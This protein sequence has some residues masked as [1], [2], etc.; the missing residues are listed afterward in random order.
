MREFRFPAIGERYFAETL[1]C[2]LQVRV[3]PKPEF[4]KTYAFF[5]S[6][7][8]SIDTDFT[9]DGKEMT[10]PDGVA[11]YLE[12]KMFDMPD[13][14]AMQMFSRVGGSPNAFTGYT[15]TAYYVECTENPYENLDIL[16]RFVSTPHF[17]EENVEK[18]RGII[19]QEI[20]MYEDS[21]DSRLYENL[22]AALYDHHPVRVP[23]AGSVESIGKITAQTLR[24]CHRAFYDP[25]N[26]MLCVAGPVEPEQVLET[27][28]RVLP[29]KR[30]GVSARDYGAPES[31]TGHRS[32]IETQMEVSMPGF[33][34]GF[35]CEPPERGERTLRQELLGDI[36]SELLA[37]ESSALYTRLYE[38]GL[39]DC[40]FS[41][42]YEGLKGAAMLSVSGDSRD[43]DAVMDAILR[44]AE[45]I[46]REG[47]DRALFGRLCKSAFGRRVRELDSFENICYR[48]CQSCFEGAEYYDFPTLYRGITAEEAAEF[49]KNTVR[50]ERA[51][52]SIVRPKNKEG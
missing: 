27:A 35:K 16:L 15:M 48:M 21:A 43:P 23:I 31:M 45:R 30:G 51:A 41:V 13:G 19:A 39:I 11:H 26:M 29:G 52:I 24:D 38:E 7:Y 50:P 4:A 46:G 28:L 42:G 9:L 18:E 6:D 44:E 37:G 49:I 36:A 17:T 8:G 12:H 20:R 5:A 14:N 3:V 40:D 33:S 2:G 32:R 34:L 22:F 10:T 47:P 1:P 25:S